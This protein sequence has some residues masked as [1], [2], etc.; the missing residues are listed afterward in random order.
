MSKQKIQVLVIGGGFAGMMAAVRLAGKAPGRVAITLVNGSDVFIRRLRLHEEA[1][2]QTVPRKPIA[3]MLKGTGVE[4]VQGMVRSLDPAAHTI[5]VELPGGGMRDLPYDYLVYALGSFVDQDAVPGLR[6]H[7]YVLNPAGMMAAPQ[8]K[9][10]L[11]ELKNSTAR[12][13]VV[14]G[15]A[16]G[17]ESAAQ[18][19]GTHPGF[20]VELV[21]QGAFG[22]FKN[23][24]LRRHMLTA[25]A[26]QDIVIREHTGIK[27]VEAGGVLTAQGEQNRGGSGAVGGRLQVPD[28][29]AAS[30]A[31]GQ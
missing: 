13:L 18:I 27:A 7:A 2:G 8:L 12:V 20:R 4:F 29:G 6:E 10:R 25:F 11:G 26:R 21:T 9:T 5:Q 23:E 3:A 28:A 15:G 24:R 19:K 1:T 30:R 16:T 14:G 17:I 22:A 31:G